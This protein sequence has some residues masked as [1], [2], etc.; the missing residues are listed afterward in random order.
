MSDA[1]RETLHGGMTSERGLPLAL[2]RCPR[3]GQPLRRDGTALVSL[4][5]VHRYHVSASGIALFE[6]IAV[7]SDAEIQQR[8]YDRVAPAYL[9]NLA[10]PHTEEYAAYLDRAL[11]DAIGTRKLGTVVELCCG[12]GEGFGLLR[13]PV[14]LG[15]G[16]DISA[17][18]LEVARAR[19]ADGRYV[20]IQGD[21]TNLP[22]A[23]GAFDAAIINGGIHHVND[24]RRL[25]AEIARVLK[26]GGALYF[27]EP[28]DDLI[29]WRVL[30]A[31]IYRLSPALDHRTERPLRYD[32]TVPLLVEAGF[33]VRRWRTYGLLGFCLLMN[34]DVLVVNRLLRFVPGIRAIARTLA[35]FDDWTAR[36]PGL[37]G[38]ALQV[39]GWARKTDGVEAGQG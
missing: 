37:R 25:F 30:R 20:F 35:R 28:C 6:E 24:R 23:T 13:A 12:A 7:T 9:A 39:V 8:H 17:R 32:E 4:D 34:S 33:E 22:L 16:V 36:F 19:Y 38:K 26:P 5:G 15:V 2:L 1:A 21:A 27:R 14:D 29:L 3:S 11:N 31:V 18:M 10:Y